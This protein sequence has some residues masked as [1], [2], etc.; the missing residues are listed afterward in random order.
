[1]GD[2]GCQEPVPGAPPFFPKMGFLRV[3]WML[4]PF[5]VCAQF[6]YQWI[7][8]DCEMKWKDFFFFL[9]AQTF[10]KI[11]AIFQHFNDIEIVLDFFFFSI[12]IFSVFFSYPIS[13]SLLSF[14]FFFFFHLINFSANHITD[15]LFFFIRKASSWF[16]TWKLSCCKA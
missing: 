4:G 5:F 8:K 13:S 16:Q 3:G 14:F 7:L 1:M 2:L 15:Y 12:S 6:M 10:V 11:C 9:R